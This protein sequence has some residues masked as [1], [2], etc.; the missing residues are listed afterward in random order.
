MRADFYQLGDETAER[1]IPLLASKIKEAGGKLLVVSGDPAQLEAIGE[2]LWADRPADFLAHGM[3][4]AAHAARQ[5][6]LLS[7]DCTAANGARLVMFA[8]GLW[9]DEGTG[10]ERAFLLFGAAALEGARAAWRALGEREDV[11][12]RFWKRE[13]GKWVEGP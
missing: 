6:V 1:T 9:R 8:D 5:P 4:G 7:Q 11:E 12:R 13:G 3:A 2:A 10:F